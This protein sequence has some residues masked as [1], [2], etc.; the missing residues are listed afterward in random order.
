MSTEEVKIS[1][2]LITRNRPDSLDRC[3]ASVRSQSLQPYEIVVSDDSDDE[4]MEP[5]EVIAKTWDCQY[6]RG[7]RRGLQANRNCAHA[8][9]TG[10]HIRTMDDDHQFPEDHFKTVQEVVETDPSSVWLI[11]EY[12]TSPTESSQIQ[13]PGEVQPRGFRKPIVN[14]DRC[15]AI[16]DGSAIYP[17]SIIDKHKFIEKYQYAGEL[18]FGAR[19]QALGYRIRYSPKTY[20]I[21]AGGVSHNSKIVKNSSFIGSYLTYAVYQKHLCKSLECLSYFFSLSVIGSFKREQDNFNIWDFWT[22]LKEGQYY[23]ELFRLKKYD[24]II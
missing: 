4:F 3:L 23:G 21:H 22:T 6:I 24:R 9:C 13:L 17:K 14:F 15:F 10:T 5:T 18:E 2:A 12:S 11:G 7:P 16:S 20:V 8:A 19:L 1:V